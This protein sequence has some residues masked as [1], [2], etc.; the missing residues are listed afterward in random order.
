MKRVMPTLLMVL[1]AAAAALAARGNKPARP[2]EPLKDRLVLFDGK[3]LDAWKADEEAKKHWAIDGNVL[4]YDGKNRTLWTKRSFG[5]FVLKMDWRMTRKCDSGIYLRG[6]SKAQIN[7][8]YWKMGSGEVWGYRTD[9]RMPEEVRKA[10]TPKKN[11]D[12]PIGEWNTFVITMTGDRLTVVLNGQEVIS[13]ARLPGVP[14]I[15]PIA[16]QHH[17]DPIEFRN[18]TIEPV[19]GA[20]PSGMIVPKKKMMLFNGKDLTGW[21]PFLGRS[22][23][24][25]KT[26]WSV[27]G[28]VIRCE[29]RPNGYIRTTAAYANYKLHL[30]WRW[31]K[32]G[33]N[34]GVLLHINGPDRVWPKCVE[35]QLMSRNAGD[36]FFIG[37]ATCTVGGKKKAGRLPKKGDPSEKPLGQWNSYDITCKGDAIRL[38]INGELKNEASGVS[39]TSGTI[40]LQSEGGPIEFRNVYVEPVEPPKTPAPA[41]A[42][43]SGAK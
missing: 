19:E 7:I 25:P 39:V 21:K 20:A 33:S 23:V 6:S 36:F 41:P 40:G 12:K 38:V 35:A 4:K 13:N 37:G 5:D 10:C 28:G 42:K 2:P 14:K 31:V 11:A 34:S 16:L 15:G 29:G 8:W 43:K 17:G 9:K 22:K 30:E 32:R 27:V 24:D 18:I 1:L 3:N 26:V